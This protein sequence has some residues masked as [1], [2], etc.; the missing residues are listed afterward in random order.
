MTR[1]DDAIRRAQTWLAAMVAA[2]RPTDWT[3]VRDFSRLKEVFGAA[4]DAET[5]LAALGPASVALAMALQARRQ[6]RDDPDD[7]HAD[8]CEYE[9]EAEAMCPCGWGA[10]AE[11]AQAAGERG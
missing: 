11:W 9:P 10:L 3:Q 4:R 6:W 5:A 1:P 8:W 2:E 7:D